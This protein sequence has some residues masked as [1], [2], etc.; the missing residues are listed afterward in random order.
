MFQGWDNFYITAGSAAATL[1]G[2]LFVVI[3]LGLQLS[4]SPG[5]R[6]VHAFLT[7]TLVHF[8]GVLLQ[9][10]ML[11]VPWPSPWP[12]GIILILCGLA[13]LA[14]VTIVVRLLRTLDFVALSLRDW[15]LYAAAPA[16]AN[17]ALVAGAI[18]LIARQSFAP[19][20]V[21]GG[22]V[23]L[24]FV[25]IRDAWDLTLWIVRNRKDER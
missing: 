17:A 19:Y 20:A 2:L 8:G 23:L 6:G 25:G 9:S 12:P 22:V 18:G 1:T 16:L 13:G 7:P 4:T 11:L 3:T 21:A 10:L 24:L 15:I 5:M 14:Y